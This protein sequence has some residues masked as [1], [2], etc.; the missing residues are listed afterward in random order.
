MIFQ[1]EVYFKWTSI[2]NWYCPIYIF[3]L[4]YLIYSRRFNVCIIRNILF[5]SLKAF[6]HFLVC[7][8]CPNSP[9]TRLNLYKIVV[10]A[11]L[12]IHFYQGILTFKLSFTCSFIGLTSYLNFRM[13]SITC[14][15][16]LSSQI[17]LEFLLLR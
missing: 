13:E 15:W 5:E 14:F 10:S 4:H 9:K 12:N 11:L 17:L 3:K 16:Q 8:L 6:F 1:M 2:C 7:L